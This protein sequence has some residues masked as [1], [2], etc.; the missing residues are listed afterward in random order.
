MSNKLLDN[1]SWNN[2]SWWVS[3][4]SKNEIEANEMLGLKPRTD[5]LQVDQRQTVHDKVTMQSAQTVTSANQHNGLGL[6]FDE[7][8]GIGLKPCTK[9]ETKSQNT[10]TNPKTLATKLQG[11]TKLK[12]SSRLQPPIL[13]LCSMTSSSSSSSSCEPF[14]APSSPS[15]VCSH[16]SLDLPSAC[17]QATSSP[18]LVA[19]RSPVPL[20]FIHC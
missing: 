18:D 17:V 2:I 12:T 10:K 4:Y 1:Y 9:H 20:N 7:P 16:S 8:W 15:P 6:S 14:A 11:L 5:L 3:G 19:P 13:H